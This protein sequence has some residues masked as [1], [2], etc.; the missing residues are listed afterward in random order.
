[1]TALLTS[2]R[3]ARQPTPAQF[4]AAHPGCWVQYFDDTP[5]RDASKALAARVFDPDV[6]RR[7]QAERC[8]VCFSLQA[9]GESRTKEGLLCY[10]N[11]GVDVDLVPAAERGTLP[12]DA[13]D[14]RKDEYLER[15]LLPFPLKP[16]WVTETRHGF[17]VIFRVKPVREA[18][19]V[20]DAEAVNRRLVCSLRGDENASLL[21][22]VLRVPGTLQFK[23][24]QHP[25]LCRL[26]TDNA[27]QIPPYDLD[28]VRG[29]LD[30]A[31][32]FR[33]GGGSA[34]AG[35]PGPNVPDQSRRW[36]ERLAGVPEGRRNAAAA[37]VVGGILARLPEDFWDT[38]GWG[39]LKEWN[40]RN[41]TPLPEREL[42][43]V[44]ES[45]ARRERAKRQAR[46]GLEKS[47]EGRGEI[48][49]RV[50]GG[51]ATDP[52]Q[53][54]IAA[55]PA[56]SAGTGAPPAGAPIPPPPRDDAGSR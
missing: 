31:E 45:I 51:R 42:R 37:S 46:G 25:F 29:V 26:L 36:R 10:R 38:A 33:G 8:A 53:V 19:A 16:H 20:R 15:H 21:T 52:P 48:H 24:P 22:Q 54:D 11:L 56:D 50:R 12:P 23:D 39:G 28:T 30:A 5:A 3:R 35:R 44:Y 43:G 13:I 17:H 9:F 27:S 14:R 47:P 32:V 6:A 1:M 18:P 2:L 49:I 34:K 4:L 55:S 41:T 40:A 7:K